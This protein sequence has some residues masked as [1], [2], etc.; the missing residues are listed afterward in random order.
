MILAFKTANRTVNTDVIFQVL[1]YIIKLVHILIEMNTPITL[2]L[3]HVKPNFYRFLLYPLVDHLLQFSHKL[4]SCL[5]FNAV[6]I[7]FR[8]KFY[9]K[10]TGHIESKFCVL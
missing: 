5:C 10:T 6:E 2:I 4:G 1:F 8:F 9:V 3:F 7:F